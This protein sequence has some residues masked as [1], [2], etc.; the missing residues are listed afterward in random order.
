[1]KYL[2]LLYRGIVLGY[3]R[4]IFGSSLVFLELKYMQCFLPLA[5]CD[6]RLYGLG[7]AASM[8]GK[9]KEMSDSN[10]NTHFDTTPGERRC[11]N[12]NIYRG[13]LP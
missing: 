12:L 10:F 11:N 5:C 4:I 1:M 8:G 3:L 13:L 6:R 7:G 9:L 2:K